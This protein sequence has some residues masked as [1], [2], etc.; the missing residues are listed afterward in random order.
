MDQK[1]QEVTTEKSS[2]GIVDKIKQLGK[3]LIAVFTMLGV[4]AIGF[5]AT[6]GVRASA[7]PLPSESSSDTS[8]G[9]LA[10]SNEGE[11][12]TRV[13]EAVAY[14]S[15]AE[16]MATSSSVTVDQVQADTDARQVERRSAKFD[17]S[18]LQY[19]GSLLRQEET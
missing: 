5:L 12:L 11:A 16:L 19:P 8:S 15:S 2:S 14:S 17:T 9:A 13:T 1:A 7:T 4:G 18:D 6:K 3:G 10:T